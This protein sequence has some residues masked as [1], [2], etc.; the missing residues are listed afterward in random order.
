MKEL[1]KQLDS[2][3]SEVAKSLNI[4]FKVG[5]EARQKKKSYNSESLRKSGVCF[6]VYNPFNVSK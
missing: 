1:I 3:F 5:N 4:T 2:D 6:L